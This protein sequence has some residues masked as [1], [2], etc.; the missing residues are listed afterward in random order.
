M[1]IIVKQWSEDIE[2]Y[3]YHIEDILSLIKNAY[4]ERAKD[5]ISFATLKYSL[6][7]FLN[8]RTDDD[9]WFLAF[10]NNHL[11]CGTARLTIIGRRGEICNFAVLPNSQGKHV[12]RQLLQTVNQFAKER[13]LDFVMSYTA[14]KAKSS[15]KC[16]CNNGFQITGIVVGLNRDYSS[17]IF[18]NQ[19]TPSFLF[20]SPFVKYRYYIS[21][22]KYKL[23]KN[24]NGQNTILGNLALYIKNLIVI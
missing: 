1:N 9:Y 23:L 5:G 20:N 8:E 10:D 22:L 4:A 17:Y 6:T 7:E 21:I 16:H 3:D 2:I 24:K 13:N 19:I 18:R 11:L 15:V 14:M 12:G